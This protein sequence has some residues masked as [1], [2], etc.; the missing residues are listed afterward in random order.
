M[1]IIGLAEPFHFRVR[2]T[3][4]GGSDIG[5]GK[6]FGKLGIRGCQGVHV[7]QH[8]LVQT[9]RALGAASSG[10]R[11]GSP[12]VAFVDRTAPLHRSVRSSGHSGI[13]WVDELSDKIWGQLRHI[14]S[15]H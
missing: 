13:S 3:V 10:L 6:L 7:R 12:D 11:R 15:L 4:D 2:A 14:I 1:A 5:V 9:D 8:D